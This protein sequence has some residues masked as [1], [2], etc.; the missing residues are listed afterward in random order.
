MDTMV[1]VNCGILE[2]SGSNRFVGEL[3]EIEAHKSPPARERG[4]E[5]IKMDHQLGSPLQARACPHDS[6]SLSYAVE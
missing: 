5:Q 4:R 2:A 3:W 1:T 6:Q